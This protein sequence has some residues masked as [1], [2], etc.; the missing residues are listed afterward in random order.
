MHEIRIEEKILEAYPAFRRGIVVAL[1]IKNDGHSKALEGM[2]N[3]AVEATNDYRSLIVTPQPVAA[4]AN[5]VP[6]GL[7]K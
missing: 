2:L 3:Q 4:V 1:N 7:L 5:A 6:S